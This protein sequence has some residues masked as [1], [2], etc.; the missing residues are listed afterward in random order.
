VL[1]GIE[2]AERDRCVGQQRAESLAELVGPVHRQR[3]GGQAVERIGAVDD[4]AAA[5]RK[6]RELERGLDRLR[7]AVAEVDPIEVWRLREQPL[8]EDAG[9][10]RRVKLGEVGELGVDHVMHGP[11]D[12]RVV[13]PQR[14]HAEAGQHVEVVVALVVVKVGALGPRIDLVEADRV[15][16]LR[17]LRVHVPR[18]QL[19]PL[20]A[21]RCQQSAEIE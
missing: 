19:V 9:Q 20:R 14:E 16:H 11:L 10:R 21:A 7:P 6:A 4:P 1:Q 15:Q 8:G 17:Q 2:I 18:L 5:G 13:A 12:H 3:T